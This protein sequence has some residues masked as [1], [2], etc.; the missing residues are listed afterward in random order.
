MF[1]TSDSHPAL[2]LQLLQI[3]LDPKAVLFVVDTIA[4]FAAVM[5]HILL[6]TVVAILPP[7]FFAYGKGVEFVLALELVRQRVGFSFI[8]IKGAWAGLVSAF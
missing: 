7:A 5:S 4:A 1:F 3:N 8:L 2:W 6:I